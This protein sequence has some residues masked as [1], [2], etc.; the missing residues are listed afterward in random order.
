[1]RKILTFTLILILTVSCT[2]QSD[3]EGGD[4]NVPESDAFF[5]KGADISWATEMEDKGLKFYIEPGREMECTALFKEIGFNSV[6]FR[7]WVNPEGGYCGKE[8]L[9][10]K[11]RRAQDLG[12]K[13]LIDFHYSDWWADPGK[14]NVP[15]AWTGQSVEEMAS[16]LVQHTESTLKYLKDSGI[17]ISWAQVGNEVENGM[18]WESGRVQGNTAENFAT[19]FNA[20]ASA[21]RRVYPDAEVILHVSN[22]WKAETLIWFY[23]LMK[24]NNVAYDIIGLS[25]YPSYWQDGQYPDWST[26]TLQAVQ[27]FFLLHDTYGKDIMLVE[28]GMPV[29]QPDRAKDC[30]QYLLDSTGGREWFKGIFLWEPESEKTRNNYDYGAFSNGRPTSA[31]DPFRNKSK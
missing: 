1:M 24:A 25:L 2:G 12:M 4:G 27:N 5:A 28:F 9:L 16:S 15:A 19:Y 23:D 6:R 30:L 17:D 8:D 20:G 14:Q 18:L 26:K 22:S 10:R 31:L 13:I 7:V 21:V 3:S 11:C 29:S